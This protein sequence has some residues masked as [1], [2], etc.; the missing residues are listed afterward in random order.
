M[1]AIPRRKTPEM[2]E[3]ATR[4]D[5]GNAGIARGTQQLLPNPTQASRAQVLDRRAADEA[6]E[7][8]FQGSAPDA[9]GPCKLADRP[10]ARRILLDRLQRLGQM[11]GT[12]LLTHEPLLGSLLRLED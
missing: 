7:V 3:A 6:A 2:A 4:G 8:L 12:Q 5:L 1:L 9:A 11:P 10:G